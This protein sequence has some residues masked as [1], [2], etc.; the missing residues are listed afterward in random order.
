M[1]LAKKAEEVIDFNLMT[2]KRFHHLFREFKYNNL[3]PMNPK[4]SP[5]NV[6]YKLAV[7]ERIGNFHEVDEGYTGEQA[8][9]EVN[10]CLRCDVRC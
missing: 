5:K 1:G 9:N 6:S 8:R 7:N 3:I 2:E 10:R 4:K